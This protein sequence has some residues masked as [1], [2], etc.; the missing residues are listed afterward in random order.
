M[1]DDVEAL[2]LALAAATLRADQAEIALL[3]VR[4]ARSDDQALIAHLKLQIEKLKHQLFG[5]KSERSRRLLD[6]LELQLE[7]LEA[8][9]SQDEAV[10]QIAARKVAGVHAQ[11]L[12]GVHPVPR[13][14]ARVPGAC[15]EFCA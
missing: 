10:A 11:A 4:A 7:E 15:Q 14:W 5:S 2:K 13:R 12:A 3:G 9:A 6:Q 1:P 8:T